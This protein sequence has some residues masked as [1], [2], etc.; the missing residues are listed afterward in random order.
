MYRTD[1]EVYGQRKKR[2]IWRINGTATLW[3]SYPWE[4]CLLERLEI[5]QVANDVL[6]CSCS[7]W[8]TNY[9]KS[10]KYWIVFPLIQRRSVLFDTQ[11][12]FPT[13]AE[14][15]I[16]AGSWLPSPDTVTASPVLWNSTWL[17]SEREL[18][19]WAS[20]TCFQVRPHKKFWCTFHTLECTQQMT[21]T[22]DG[23]SV[24]RGLNIWPKDLTNPICTTVSIIW[25]EWQVNNS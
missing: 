21:E 3:W 2:C 7:C 18:K 1:F 14:V 11:T 19:L 12:T 23:H 17:D 25:L 9:D 4:V 20:A 13:D 24:M 15:K 6:T 16:P 10:F 8:P 22:S 5:W